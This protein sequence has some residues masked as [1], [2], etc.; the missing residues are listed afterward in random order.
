MGQAKEFVHQ[1]EAVGEPR[2]GSSRGGLQGN[3]SAAQQL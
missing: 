3:G 2:G 1:S